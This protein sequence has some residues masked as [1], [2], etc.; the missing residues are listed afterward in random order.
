M[1][2]VVADYPSRSRRAQSWSAAGVARHVAGPRRAWQGFA[3]APAPACPRCRQRT[4]IANIDTTLHEPSTGY[5]IKIA[6]HAVCDHQNV[7]TDCSGDAVAA[8]AIGTGAPAC[9]E[10]PDAP[11]EPIDPIAGHSEANGTRP[12]ECAKA[13]DQWNDGL[14]PKRRMRSTA[15]SCKHLPCSMQRIDGDLQH[16]Q[17]RNGSGHSRR[18]LQS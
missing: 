13:S 9:H 11:S 15:V 1:I 18:F 12:G 3:P 17:S 5:R 7:S 10:I 8:D 6:R 2:V 14:T 16:T 4:L